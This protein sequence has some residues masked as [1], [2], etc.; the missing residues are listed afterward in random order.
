MPV[1]QPIKYSRG[2][3]QLLD[4]R[5]L[6][7]QQ[8]YLQIKTCEEAHQRIRQMAVRGAPAIAIAGVLALAVELHSSGITAGFDSATAAAEGISCRLD[9]L[10]TRHAHLCCISRSLLSSTSAC[11]IAMCTAGVC[12]EHPHS[13]WS[14]TISHS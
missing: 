3:L 14:P 7:L 10:V 11:L 4:Q 9:Y 13:Q 8:E 2:E 1:L 6:P 5:L 12:L